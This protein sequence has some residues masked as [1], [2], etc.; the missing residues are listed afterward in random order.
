MG[1]TTTG[2]A[3]LMLG[4]SAYALS[5]ASASAASRCGPKRV[6]VI[7]AGSA[8][9]ASARR[10]AE[11]G[12]TPVVLERGDAVGGLWELGS[13]PGGVLYQ[14]LV[15]N[16]P[17][18][19]MAYH[20]YPFPRE[21]PSFVR[22]HDMAAYLTR[23]ADAHALRPMVR[24]HCDVQSIEPAGPVREDSLFGV[25]AWRV[26][27]LDRSA[28]SCVSPPDGT[29]PSMPDSPHVMTPSGGV[30]HDEIFDAVV[31]A[32][33]HYELPAAPKFDGA[34]EFEAAG[35]RVEHAADYNTPDAYANKKVLLV[36]A[37]ASG[38]DIAREVASV[39][40][41]VMVAD[42]SCARPERHESSGAAAGAIWRFPALQRLDGNGRA[43]FGIRGAAEEACAPEAADVV[44]LCTGYDYHLPFLQG[45]AEALG[46]S[47]GNRRV[48]PLFLQ[49][50]AARAPS[51]AMVGVP[52]SVVPFPLFD[53]QA[54]LVAEVLRGGD[55]ARATLRPLADRLAW[56][57][58]LYR[59]RGRPEDSHHLGGLQW[60]YC[61]DLAR[62]GGFLDR[63]LESKLR[64]S[65]ALY[66][67]AQGRRPAY[68][69]ADDV[70]RRNNYELLP[71]EPPAPGSSRAVTLGRARVHLHDG[72][73]EII[74]W[75][76]PDAHFGEDARG[77]QLAR[78][79]A[80]AAAAQQQ[81]RRRMA[82]AEATVDISYRAVTWAWPRAGRLRVHTLRCAEV[83]GRSPRGTPAS[84]GRRV[85]GVAEMK[86][87][88]FAPGP[89]TSECVMRPAKRG[90]AITSETRKALCP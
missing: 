64:M 7:G 88:A 33:G 5:S 3:R 21:L 4:V 58:E 87:A 40:A 19:I 90:V 2:A 65:Q 82:H 29:A 71:A 67:D 41:H 13:R 15:T 53:V 38:T 28:Q 44:I 51:L 74:E 6:C 68:P 79:E 31:V 20:D 49:L 23:F 63:A 85:R 62:R 22:S 81:L 89:W 32:N 43:H 11:A 39:A 86:I 34:S 35:G 70:Y 59:T 16:L 73:Q 83:A 25:D 52:H 50:F 37:R 56:V 1:L 69:G 57:E 42:T 17:K 45:A 77:A 36:G 48:D 27:W 78:Q 12:H 72:S 46:L 18:E 54:R 76:E 9:L 75:E 80:A 10:L 84:Q 61:R 24:L 55:A 14:G 26:R 47:T 30:E 66:E 8:G 60:D